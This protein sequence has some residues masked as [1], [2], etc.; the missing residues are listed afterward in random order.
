MSEFDF[1]VTRDGAL[2]RVDLNRPDEGNSLTRAM[3]IRL[4]ALLRELGRTPDINVVAIGGRGGQFCRGRDG[5][6]ESRAG[7]TPYEVR[8]K[9]MG[10]VLDSYQAIWDVPVPVVALVHGDALGYGAALAVGCDITLAASNARFAF[11]EIEH[12]IPPTMAMC[13]ALGKIQAKALTYLIYSAEQIDAE[14][15]VTLGLASKVL[16]QA[17]FAADAEAFITRL[18][19]RPHLVLETIKRYQAKAAHLTPD[20]ASEYAGT[21]MALVRS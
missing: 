15:A 14:Q 16:P 3:M 13:A 4:A 7:M 12:D 10:A 11:P 9:M 6:G 1:E 5:R 20:M 8:V 2:A 17:S 18:A 19:A 21:L